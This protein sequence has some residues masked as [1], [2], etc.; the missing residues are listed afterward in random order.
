MS[1]QLE[2]WIVNTDTN[3]C[4]IY[5]YNNLEGKLTQI[6]TIIHPECKLNDIELTSDRPGR[7]RARDIASGAYAP[8]SDP[9]SVKIQ[10]F[11]QEISHYL[12]HGRTTNAYQELIIIAL[13][14]MNGLLLKLL[15]EKVKSFITH[16][17]EKNIIKYNDNQLID[18][19]KEH[20]SHQQ[21]M[22]H[23]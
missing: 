17:I 22:S 14:H 12:D 11:A 16:N 18:F 9:K 7:Y 21:K 4:K 6:K 3:T 20:T 8:H 5:S 10:Q 15:P 13:P 1:H 2:K 23:R 19:F